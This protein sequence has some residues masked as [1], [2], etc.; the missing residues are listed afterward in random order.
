[1]SV[2]GTPI[3]TSLLQAAQAQQVAGKARDREKAASDRSARY[4]DLLDLR[5]AA[6]ESTE[7]VR[8]LP[9]NDSEQAESEH[10]AKARPDSTDATDAGEERP[11]IDLQA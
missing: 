3:E 9:Q 10:D 2:I 7:A 11:R 8:Q 5:I 1:M 4:Q 6:V